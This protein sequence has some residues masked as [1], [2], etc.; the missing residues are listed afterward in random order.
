MKLV[1]TTP[2]GGHQVG[3]EITDD[4]AI[5]AVLESEQAAFV[6]QVAADPPPKSK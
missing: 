6:T 5:A 4:K 2:F 3:D 1:V